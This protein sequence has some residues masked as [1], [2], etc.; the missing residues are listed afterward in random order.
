[1][2]KQ[3][4]FENIRKYMAERRAR[5]IRDVYENEDFPSDA[6]QILIP[7]YEYPDIDYYDVKK[8]KKIA[9]REVRYG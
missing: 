6:L 3:E 9:K 4:A 2:T 5:H 1:M 8:L 7:N